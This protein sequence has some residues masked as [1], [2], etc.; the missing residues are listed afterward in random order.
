MSKRFDFC[1]IGSGTAG[2]SLS[3]R[4]SQKGS[5]A[6]ITKGNI[7]SGS[8]P[9]AQGGIASAPAIKEEIEGHFSDTMEAGGN[10]NNPNTVRLLVE[11]APHIINDLKEWGVEFSPSL[12][13]EG[14]HSKARIYHADDQTGS[15]ISQALIKLVQKNENIIIFEKKKVFRLISH[16]HQILGAWYVDANKKGEIYSKPIFAKKT[17]LATGG[18]CGIFDPCTV[19]EDMRGEGIVMAMDIGAKTMDLDRVQFHPTVLDTSRRPRFLL[20]EA[21]RGAG[22]ILL[23]SRK[24]HFVN[25]LL[26]RDIISEHIIEQQKEGKVFLDARPIQDFEKKFPHIFTV[27]TKEWK[28]DPRI[29]LLPISPAAHFFGGGIQTDIYGRT[30]IKNLSAVGEVAWT[31]VHGRNRLASNSLLECLVFAKQIS[32]SF[33]GEEMEEQQYLPYQDAPKFRTKTK[34][35]IIFEE[36]MRRRMSKYCGVSREMDGL[37]KTL[38]YAKK[39]T[40]LGTETVL[41]K[42]M[43]C[44][45]L[46]A[47]IR[48][49]S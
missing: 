9:L 35:D 43:V 13:R 42:K 47:A 10:E 23:N 36:K 45:V 37:Q 40:V 41:F 34:E 31:G 22:A 12:H 38:L 20:S 26:P 5:V 27:L 32:D 18:A 44:A 46:E 14:G 33:S 17:I 1:I 7:L 29:E 2:L 30:N 8:S 6:L 25:E 16:E 15:A 28:K 21:L 3:L 39:G 4:L 48:R 11:N 24:E 49:I 19:P